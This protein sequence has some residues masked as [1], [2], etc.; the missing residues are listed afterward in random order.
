MWFSVPLLTRL[1][2]RGAVS[3]SVSPMRPGAPE[4]KTCIL[5][6]RE[7]AS[8]KALQGFGDVESRTGHR[9]GRPW[10]RAWGGRASV[11]AVGSGW[12]LFVPSLFLE[13]LG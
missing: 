9:E 11:R 7:G 5:A 13:D 6:S 8:L 10:T 4:G 2:L 1:W 12:L 3:A